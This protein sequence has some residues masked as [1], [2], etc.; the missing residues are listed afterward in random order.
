MFVKNR[1]VVMSEIL[2]EYT[3]GGKVENIHRADVA[4]VNGK[5]EGVWEFGNSYRPMF[6][7]S[8]AKP[9]QV[10]PFI[11]KGG[12]ERYGFTSEEVAFMVSSH[13]GE[14]I[15]VGLVEQVLK[16]IGLA[17][18]VLACGTS[19]PLSSKAAKDLMLSK[20]PFGAVHNPC[21]G[22]HSGM[23]AL[24]T[25]LGIEIEGY[26]EI[27]HP[28][29][30][31]MHQAV[32]DSANLTV[33]QVETGID[34]CGVPVFYLPLFNMAWAYA[35]LAK[36]ELGNWGEREKYV[37]IIRDAMLGY[38]QVVAGTKRMDTVLMNATKGRILA[39]I[40]ADAVYCLANVEEGIGV[41]FKM[42]DGGH[43]SINAACMAIV[44]KLGWLTQEEYQQLLGQF[45][46]TLKNHRG[47][48][49]GTIEAKI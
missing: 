38:P 35:R 45:P 26:T 4:V 29:Q 5:G 11:E 48:S 6:W 9:F 49:I 32:A 12:M 44:N 36:P 28:V 19:K 46:L 15:H 27:E 3:R 39:K 21:S 25:M 34:G 37:R 18:D 20:Q 2:L 16:K 7:R 40:G 43:A 30:Q 17:T 23:L 47:D 13:S 14:P 31:I 22:K 41:A 8:A 24:A 1:G 33:E 42:E 10:L